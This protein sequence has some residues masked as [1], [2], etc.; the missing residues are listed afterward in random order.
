MKRVT[1]LGGIFFKSESPKDLMAWYKEHLGIQ[2]DE[3]GG[4]TFEWL[5]K[6]NP[7]RT[8]MTVFNAFKQDTNYF[9]PASVP[10]MFNFRV[11]DVRALVE[12]LKQEGVQVV[13]EVQDTEYGKFGWILDP[14][15]RKIELWQPPDEETA[16]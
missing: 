12:Q 3:Y 8:G 2:P 14:E 5:E 6:D 13:G 9:D 11:E 1:G 16:K 4:S 15:G 7:K 10:Y